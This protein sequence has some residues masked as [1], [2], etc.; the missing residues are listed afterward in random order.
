MNKADR[1]VMIGRRVRQVVLGLAAVLT[2]SSCVY[3]NGIYNAQAF[4]DAG[5]A[6]LRRDAEDDARAQFQQSAARAE[7]VLVRF[8]ASPWRARALYLAGRGAALAGECEQGVRRLE[9]F[10]AVGDTGRRTERDRARLAMA[11]CAIRT[12]QVADARARLDSLLG[13]AH[14]ETAR[15]ARLWAARAALA[16]GD[17]P[18][19]T[20]YLAGMEAGTLPWEL[21]GAALQTGDLTP[22]ESLLV[23]RA[24]RGDFRDEAARAIR[25]LAMAGRFES[26]ERIVR[27]YTNPRVR[28]QARAALHFALGDQW[29]RVGDDSSA[30]RHLHAARD[31]A[32]RDTVLAGDAGVRL[33]Y[34]G[35]RRATSL[36]SADSA[37]SRID[38]LSRRTMMARRLE[39]QLLLMRVLTTRDE[40]TGAGAYLAAEV[41]RDSVRAPWLA[42]A[43]FAHLATTRPDAPV[44][45]MAWH[46]A[47]LLRPDSAESW[48]RRIRT[49]YGFSSIAARLQGEDPASRPDFVATPELLKFAWGDGVRVWS[50]SVRRLRARPTP[51]SRPVSP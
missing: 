17:L 18:A 23:D 39:E 42:A 44:A 46:A 1:Q 34:L 27:A 5:D 32:G 43:L 9:E 47:S 51:G 10:L 13:S 28:P 16:Q 24:R 4:A 31:L 19:V 36:A 33:G 25:D 2:T 21:V 26:A 14:P 3:Y 7:T 30:L 11:S 20:R 37:W 6:R 45:P 8:P 15:Q 35:L 49:Q 50:D 40:A 12:A 41:A 22:V 29:L 38:S 48:Q